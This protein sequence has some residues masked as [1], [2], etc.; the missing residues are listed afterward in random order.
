MSVFLWLAVHQ[1]CT[2]W[3]RVWGT[4][5]GMVSPISTSQH[6]TLHRAAVKRY[7]PAQDIYLRYWDTAW[8]GQIQRELIKSNWFSPLENNSEIKITSIL[9]GNKCFL[10]DPGKTEAPEFEWD[11]SLV[12]L[13]HK[14]HQK[15]RAETW[16]GNRSTQGAI[17]ACFWHKQVMESLHCIS[18][19]WCC[20]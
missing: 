15:W 12:F 8:A 1:R 11:S 9:T 2:H 5:M 3:S 4:P 14:Q 16:E 10:D 13:W 7:H 20:D 6:D 19:C 18:F 17:W